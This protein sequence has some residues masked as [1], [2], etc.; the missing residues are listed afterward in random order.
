M[1]KFKTPIKDYA[2]KIFNGPH[3]I[4]AIIILAALLLT[5]VGG[6]VFWIVI[7]PKLQ[8]TGLT[9][10]AGELTDYDF[11]AEISHQKNGSSS[12]F[13]LEGTVLRSVKQAD[14]KISTKT[15]DNQTD[16]SRIVID[17]DDAYVDT[18]SLFTI[19][20]PYW[21]GDMNDES[22]FQ[23]IYNELLSADTT[24]FT[25]REYC[26]PSW[27]T[28][29]QW[30]NELKSCSDILKEEAY[31]SI[32]DSIKYRNAEKGSE[33]TFNTDELSAAV[34]SFEK[35]LVPNASFLYHHSMLAMG[36]YGVETEQVSGI[37]AQSLS[38]YFTALADNRRENEEQ[39][40]EQLAAQIEDMLDSLKNSISD[41]N[42]EVTYAVSK[43]GKYYTQS[44][45]ITAEDGEVW[46]ITL[47]KSQSYKTSIDDI[48]T[49]YEE[50]GVQEALLEQGLSTVFD[51][52]IL[53]EGS[54][55]SEVAE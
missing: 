54:Q 3:R 33:V 12:A 15:D 25:L 20:G 18:R 19:T 7:H 35:L 30:V 32:K 13:C 23:T 39:G 46:D 27:D 44:I 8:V 38:K 6:S 49:E 10:D 47:T 4:L 43:D 2:N 5:I 11:T 42:A 41:K 51:I 24:K 9:A 36:N 21:L 22:Y 17:G 53:N 1:E 31:E 37:F 16:K 28:S 29:Y 14:I 26:L 52:K 48:P 50:F 55:G 45:T 34:D 40:T